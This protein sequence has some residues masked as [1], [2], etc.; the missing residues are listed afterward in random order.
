MVIASHAE[1]SGW[2]LLFQGILLVG[3]GYFVWLTMTNG[4]VKLAHLLRPSHYIENKTLN[5]HVGDEDEVHERSGYTTEVVR[6][7]MEHFE[8][9]AKERGL[10]K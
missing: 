9:Q 4:I 1:V 7:K 6:E 3:V 2:E 8:K 5:L 10:G